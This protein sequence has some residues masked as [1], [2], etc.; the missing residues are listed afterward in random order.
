VTRYPTGDFYW[1]DGDMLD[2]DPAE[3]LDD[4]VARKACAARTED[5]I[6]YHD[7][8]R[9]SRQAEIVFL[10]PIKGIKTN[11]LKHMTWVAVAW[12]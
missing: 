4:L 3:P 6:R 11:T 7:Q 2:R 8:Y 12:A 10:Q 1:V 9:P 5:I